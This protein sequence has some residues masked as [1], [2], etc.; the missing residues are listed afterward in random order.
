MKRITFAIFATLLLMASTSFAVTS[1]TNA[2]SVSPTL[3]VSATVQKAVRL[4]L[5]VGATG[6]VSHCAVAAGGGTDYAMDFG[7][8][9]ALAIANG[10]C[11]KFAPTTAGVSDAIYWSDYSLTPVFTSHTT[12]SNTTIT[13][14]VTT[15]FAAPNNLYVVRDNSNSNAAAVATPAGPGSFVA[16]STG[17]ADTIGAAGLANGTAITRFIGVGVKPL[18]ANNVVYTQQTATVT[19]TLTVQ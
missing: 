6:G 16:I 7:T 9:D 14:Q 19:F 10:N 3:S 8:V 13:A 5:A 2:S 4:T 15:D 18:N 12:A 17:S 11:N 1:A